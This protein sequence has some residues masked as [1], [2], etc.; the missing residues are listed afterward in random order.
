MNRLL[1]DFFVDSYQPKARL[2]WDEHENHYEV[3]LNLAGFKK[4]KSLL[5]S[6]EST[7]AGS[8]V[9]YEDGLLTIKI[10]KKESAKTIE[11]KIK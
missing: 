11:L 6:E 2:Y 4:D 10:N 8:S 9:S 7:P 3:Q 1:D 5:I